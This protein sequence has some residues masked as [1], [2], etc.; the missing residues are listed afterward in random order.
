MSLKFDVLNN[1][2]LGCFFVSSSSEEFIYFRFSSETVRTS[3]DLSDN[4]Q[5]IIA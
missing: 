2:F 4:I 5:V 3:R 1:K